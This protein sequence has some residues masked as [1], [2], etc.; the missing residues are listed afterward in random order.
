M[1][2][3]DWVA[4]RRN[5]LLKH[6]RFEQSNN[7]SHHHLIT[8]SSTFCRHQQ[9]STPRPLDWTGS[10]DIHH[11]AVGLMHTLM[12]TGSGQV[13]SC[14]NNDYGQLGQEMS[15]K[16]PRMFRFSMCSISSLHTQN[17]SESIHLIL[18]I[19][20]SSSPRPPHIL[21]LSLS[22][23]PRTLHTLSLCVSLCPPAIPAQYQCLL[24]LSSTCLCVSLIS[25]SSCRNLRIEPKTV[26][27]PK[28][29]FPVRPRERR[30]CDR[31][32]EL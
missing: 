17:I 19:F 32:G 1:A 25:I 9:I 12:L 20:I 14:G 8:N 21:F 4:S 6:D 5:R 16:R 11:I 27:I 23:Q 29:T 15:R 10:R 7:Q 26:S 13:Y 18:G 2:N 22:L 30:T 24:L 3:W 28:P 31:S